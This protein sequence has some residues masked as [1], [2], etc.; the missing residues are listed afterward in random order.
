[1]IFRKYIL[2]KRLIKIAHRLIK[3][4]GFHN[5]FSIGQINTAMEE[6][7]SSKDKQFAIQLFA[8]EEGQ[9]Y[10]NDAPFL[11]EKKSLFRYLNSDVLDIEIENNEYW[12]VLY[13]DGLSNIP[14]DYTETGI[15]GGIIY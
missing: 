8:V 2:R 4:Y 11:L 10:A 9:E 1:M 12:K 14:G 3:N 13:L 15:T 6:I 5:Y 7:K